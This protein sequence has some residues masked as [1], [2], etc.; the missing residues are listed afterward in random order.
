[1]RSTYFA[2][3][4]IFLHLIVFEKLYEMSFEFLVMYEINFIDKNQFSEHT[5]VMTDYDAQNLIDTRSVV[6][7]IK[8]T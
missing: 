1:M 6:C 5:P 3:D 4:S 2:L 8:Y 7:R